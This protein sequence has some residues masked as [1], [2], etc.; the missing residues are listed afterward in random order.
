VEGQGTTEVT[1]TDLKEW[2]DDQDVK[3]LLM[4]SGSAKRKR[5]VEQVIRIH[6]RCWGRGGGGG[7]CRGGR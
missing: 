6:P 1:L 2:T 4:A 7:A 3:P 5:Q